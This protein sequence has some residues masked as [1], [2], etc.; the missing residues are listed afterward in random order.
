MSTEID[1]LFTKKQAWI[2]TA[3][4]T[5][6]LALGMA[7]FCLASLGCGAIKRPVLKASHLTGKITL[8]ATVSADANNNSPVAVDVVQADEPKLL[9][10]MAKLTA[11]VWFAQKVDIQ[12]LHPGMLHVMSWEWV[13]GEEVAPKVIA[14]TAAAAGVVLFA[15]YASPGSHAAVL[16]QSGSVRISFGTTDFALQSAAK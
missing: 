16:P 2:G 14:G 5:C 3:I 6:T 8:Y 13:P 9:D 15:R 11:Q 10:E 12:R 1:M 4:C 7:G